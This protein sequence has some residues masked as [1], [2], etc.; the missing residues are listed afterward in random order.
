MNVILEVLQTE[1]ADLVFF[2]VFLE[3]GYLFCCDFDFDCFGFFLFCHFMFSFVLCRFVLRIPV[4][5]HVTTSYDGNDCRGGFPVLRPVYFES[6]NGKLF[7]ESQIGFLV[8]FLLLWELAARFN[9]IDAFIFSSPSRIWK[10]LGALS[11]TGDLWKHIFVSTKETVLGFLIATVLGTLVAV[12]LW[13]SK[14][15]QDI[16][17]PYLVVLNSLPKIA[18]GPIIIIWV[19][20]GEKAIVTMAVLISVIITTISM[21]NGFIGTSPDKVLLLKTMNASKFQ[22]FTKL[23]FPSNIPTLLSTLK[24]NVGLSWV[25]T[26]MGEYLNSKAGL[27]YLI[28]YGGQVFKLDLVMACTVVLCVLAAIMYL[29]VALMEKFLV[30]WKNN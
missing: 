12:V 21:L 10:Q 11:Q 15:L 29:V 30:K 27:G 22:I 2:E 16:F 3:S 8:L 9:W 25:G 6:Q 28:V 23:V 7:Q 20:A 17:E 5:I 26:I 19:G 4:L 13:W 14:S 18:L 24:I 1:S